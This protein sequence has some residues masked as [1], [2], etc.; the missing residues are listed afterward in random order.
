MINNF[1]SPDILDAISHLSSDSVFTPPR[2]VNQILDSLPDEIWQDKNIT[3]LDP[4]CK[5]GVFL[6]E[7]TNRLLEGLEKE[8]PNLEERLEHILYKQV[9]GIGLTNLTS[10]ISRRTLYCSRN[11]NGEYSIINF[12]N[13]EGNIKFFES[14]H[15]WA[16]GI[17]CKYCGVNKKKYK[18]NKDLE[19]YAYSFIHEDNPQ[20]FFNMKFDVV[21]GNPPYH[22]EDGGNGK[23]SQNIYHKFVAQAKRLDARYLVMIIPSRWFIGG[24]G[25]KNFREEMLND[26]HIKKLVDFENSKDVFPGVDVPGGVC[27]FLRDKFYEGDCEV[28]NNIKNETISSKRKLNDFDIFI[29]RKDSISIIKKVEKWREDSNLNSLSKVVSV[30]KPF[31]LP[32]NYKPRENGTDCYFIKSIGKKFAHTEDINAGGAYLNKWKVLL[33]K[34]PIAGQTDFSRP[35]KFY[36]NNNV[37]IAEPGACCTESWIIANAFNSKKEALNFRS[38]LF[39]KTFRFLL[40]QSVISQDVTRENFRFIPALKK[41]ENEI[42][43]DHLKKLWN[44]T[45]E[46]WTLIDSRI[47]ETG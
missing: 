32:T 5:S 1:H 38:Y 12:P 28:V 30:R 33:P 11:V 42:S 2:V 45:D 17:K 14:Q 25:L 19:S 6:R 35:V 15:F 18:R 9:F 27:Y 24:K 26:K 29:R 39:T 36:H 23:S 40:L 44:I 43:D 20:E 8:I 10:Q 46:E 41:Y 7:I 13:E 4:V 21:I 3:F 22:M 31:G 16:D 37:I 34:A 47:V